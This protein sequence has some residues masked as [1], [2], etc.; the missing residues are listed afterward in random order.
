MASL[1]CCE[2][3]S[4]LLP[5]GRSRRFTDG[6][7]PGLH[8]YGERGLRNETNSP[9]AHSC[10]NCNSL[11]ARHLALFFSASLQVIKRERSGVSWC[12]VHRRSKE[13]PNMLR[14]KCQHIFSGISVRHMGCRT[15]TSRPKNG[16]RLG[17]TPS[18]TAASLTSPSWMGMSS[19]WQ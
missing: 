15:F 8:L 12:L 11:H 19:P 9:L 5:L 13:T 16:S 6:K 1:L 14:C 3:L 2:R 4:D 7:Q 17:G 10:E 18:R